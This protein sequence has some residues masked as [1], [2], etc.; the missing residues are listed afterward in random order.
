MG[1]KHWG[2]YSKFEENLNPKGGQVGKCD[3]NRPL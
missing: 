3:F 2:K 1:N